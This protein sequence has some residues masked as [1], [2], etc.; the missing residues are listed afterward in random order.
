MVL[1]PLHSMAAVIP[2]A[3]DSSVPT[4]SGALALAKPG[5]VISIA[6]GIYQESL[7]IGISNLILMAQAPTERPSIHGNLSIYASGICLDGLD[8]SHWPSNKHGIYVSTR[9]HIT[10]TNCIIHGA[11]LVG[12][13]SGIYVR[14][15][16]NITI[17]HCEVYSCQKGV[18]INSARS[19]GNTF[20]N[21]VIVKHCSIHDN[22]V[23]GVDI[24]GEYITV[25]Q[26]EIFNNIDTNWA[27]THPDGIQFI[28]SVV[29]GMTNT[30][31][32]IIA[33]NR[34][35]NHSQNIFV[36]DGNDVHI[37]GNIVYCD[38]AIINGLSMFSIAT[39]NIAAGGCGINIFNNTIGPCSNHPLLVYGASSTPRTRIANNLFYNPG[40]A[41]V[42]LVDTNAFGF[43]DYNLYY[44]GSG[45]FLKIGSSYFSSLND[46]Q[47]KYGIEQHGLVIDPGSID[48]LTGELSTASPCFD[49]GMALDSLYAIDFKGRSRPQGKAWDIGAIEISFS[50]KTKLRIPETNK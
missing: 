17:T 50:T 20:R 47:S 43:C 6:P 21:G 34:I 14:E 48:W 19:F 1:L 36:E 10:I 30:T 45:S 41:P 3:R 18:N 24:H 39:K 37:F 28:K 13:A 26:N 12:S 22:P 38:D 42:W 33:R 15:S 29:D 7:D 31:H 2:V 27:S 44:F 11:G 25:E 5:D 9:N 49:S 4:I 16:H 32:V 46:A 40:R 8:I 23:D 35:R